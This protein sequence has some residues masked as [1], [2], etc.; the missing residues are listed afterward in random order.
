MAEPG[1]LKSAEPRHGVVAVLEDDLDQAR[2]LS[3]WLREG[4]YVVNHY[5]DAE[6][7][8]GD[9]AQHTIDLLLL[10]WHLPG[11]SGIDLLVRLRDGA[12]SDLPVLFL[13]A[14]DDEASIVAAL[15]NGA[16]D[17]VVKPPSKATLLARVGALIRRGVGRAEQESLELG[18]FRFDLLQRGVQLG[19]KPLDLTE[20][21]F[22]LALFLFRRVGRVVSRDAILEA[23]WRQPA[24]TTRSRT[25]DTHISR[26]RRKF[27]LD[28]RHGLRLTSVY[29]HGYRL[30]RCDSPPHSSDS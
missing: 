15:S 20:R 25:I 11:E 6:A 4:G 1:Q 5:S 17:Y 24:A 27:E 19:S 23:V 16:D 30:E 10:D 12:D 28:G 2:I 9:Q 7:F 14:R 18:L 3:H 13:T 22:D 21:E 8:R 29:Q 26:L